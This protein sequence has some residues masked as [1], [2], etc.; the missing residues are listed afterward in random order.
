MLSW[1]IHDN[2]SSIDLAAVRRGAS[3]ADEVGVDV[4]VE[5]LA[6]ADA[7]TGERAATDADRP[8]PLDVARSVLVERLGVPGMIDA[9]AVIANFEMMTRLADGTGARMTDEQLVERRD[10]SE[11]LGVN[12][13]AS[14]R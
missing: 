4:A 11:A 10:I 12:D 2:G 14:R 9:A 7:A 8:S 5:L 1:S 13:L 3:A 6:F